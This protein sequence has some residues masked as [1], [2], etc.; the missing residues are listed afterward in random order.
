MSALE[1][2]CLCTSSACW[3]RRWPVPSTRAT[4]AWWSRRSRSAVAA[5]ESPKIFSRNVHS[6]SARFSALTRAASVSKG[7]LRSAL[8]ASTERHG[9]MVLP[10]AGRADEVYDLVAIAELQPWLHQEGAGSPSSRQPHLAEGHAPGVVDAD[11][12]NSQPLALELA[13]PVR[14]PVMR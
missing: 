13:L 4:T 1:Q 12:A 5:T 6:R 3:R 14:L 10:S 7:T 2:M 9:K 8:I 11:V